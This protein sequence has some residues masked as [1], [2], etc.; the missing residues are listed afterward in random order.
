MEDFLSFPLRVS[1][2]PSLT[3]K[4]ICCV[5]F[6]IIKRGREIKNVDCL[7]LPQLVCGPEGHFRN[8]VFWLSSVETLRN[9]H[10]TSRWATGG[11]QLWLDQMP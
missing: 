5:V 9:G 2:E 10:L 7:A 11:N 3:S 6:I 1:S 4:G 8:S